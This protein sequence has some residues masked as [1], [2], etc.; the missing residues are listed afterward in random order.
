MDTSLLADSFAEQRTG[1]LRSYALSIALWSL[2]SAIFLGLFRWTLVE[3][4]TVFLEP[5]VEAA[6]AIFFVVSLIWSTIH[7]FRQRKKGPATAAIPLGVNVITALIVV[8]VPF[9]RL[10]IA[11][12]FRVLCA[13]RTEV[14]R[15][16]LAGKYENKIEHLGSGDLITLPGRLFYLSSGGEIVRERR[17]NDTLIL[18]FSFRGILSSFSGFVYSP[19]DRPPENGDFGG[20]FSEIDRLRQ[21]WFWVSSR[22]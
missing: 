3:Y 1:S 18:F 11:L 19:D 20:R 21:N 5:L 16:V 9:T 10:T 12:D 17:A 8:F 6:A 7:L 2:G 13:I 22:N 14:A 4:L 15:D